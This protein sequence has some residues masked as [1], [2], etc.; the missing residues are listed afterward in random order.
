MRDRF[1]VIG[2]WLRRE[3]A[4]LAKPRGEIAFYAGWQIQRYYSFIGI[5]LDRY[6][7]EEADYN[8]VSNALQ[9]MLAGIEGNVLMTPELQG[10]TH[11]QIAHQFAIQLWI[12]SFYVFAKILLD[13]DQRVA[14]A[15]GPTPAPVK[16]RRPCQ[17]GS[18]PTSYAMLQR[19]T[20]RG[21]ERHFIDP[22][23]RCRTSGRVL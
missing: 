8:A 2:E 14:G 21:I 6:L 4:T 11:R 16:Q 5:V 3:S 20:E 9:G 19:D 12:E 7:S 17:S 13:R 15:P 18:R 22:G 1:A 23:D 10:L